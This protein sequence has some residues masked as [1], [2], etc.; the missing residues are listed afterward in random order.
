[1][2]SPTLANPFVSKPI[3]SSCYSSILTNILFLLG[4]A[5]EK[6]DIIAF[7]ARGFIIV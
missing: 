4:N 2:D 5:F 7:P 3:D 6:N 1:M